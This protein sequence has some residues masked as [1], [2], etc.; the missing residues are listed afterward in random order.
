MKST[1]KLFSIVMENIL[2]ASIGVS[3][4]DSI[5]LILAFKK[6]NYDEPVIFHKFR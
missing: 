1:A 5:V 6:R 3:C 2:A 4:A